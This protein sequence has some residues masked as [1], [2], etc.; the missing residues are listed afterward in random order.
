ME[1]EKEAKEKEK[2]F[3]EAWKGK[4]SK[5][6]DPPLSPTP[7]VSPMTFTL[8]FPFIIDVLMVF[9]P[10]VGYIPQYISFWQTG[11][12]DGFSLKVPLVLL[13]ANGLRLAFWYVSP[14]FYTSKHSCTGY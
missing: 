6:F 1:E 10:T 3:V 9:M 5:A 11:I 13:I 7:R 2:D 14:C 4:A 8:L 12:T